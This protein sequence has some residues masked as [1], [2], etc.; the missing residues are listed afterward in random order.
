M[1]HRLPAESKTRNVWLSR[2]HTIRKHLPVNDS[3]RVCSAHFENY[4]KGNYLT[5]FHSKPAKYRPLPNRKTPDVL[6]TTTAVDNDVDFNVTTYDSV[7]SVCPTSR[8]NVYVKTQ[9]SFSASAAPDI[10]L[11]DLSES[12]DKIRFYGGFCTFKML[13]AMFHTLILNGAERLNYWCGEQSLGG[14]LYDEKGCKPDP[15]RALH[16]EEDVLERQYKTYFTGDWEISE[17]LRLET[18]SARSHNMDAEEDISMFSAA[19]QKAANATTCSL[20]CKMRAH[21]NRTVDYLDRLEKIKR[22][23]IIIQAIQ[24]RGKQRSKRRMNQK[25]LEVEA[26]RRLA[27]KRQ[28]RDTT[29]RKKLQKKLKAIDLTKI[30]K[31]LPD[32]S[33]T[34]Q[35]QIR[36]LL[37]GK[38]VE[39]NICHVWW[40]DGNKILYFGRIEKL[41]V[42]GKKCIVAY[43]SQDETYDDAADYNISVFQLAAD[44]I[45]EDL[46]M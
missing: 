7:S 17:R 24:I 29:I 12:D 13:L 42:K 6:A 27:K 9:T 25:D 2:L 40:E 43:W 20:S 44:L 34:K 45:L 8:Q 15:K 46:T 19:K 38:A 26:S 23:Q 39:S 32:V 35:Q 31:E 1:L 11:E 33:D 30:S 22:D 36:E 16:L 18:K 14:T 21:K 4:D 37:E 5:I 3:T 28:T 10:I 41:K